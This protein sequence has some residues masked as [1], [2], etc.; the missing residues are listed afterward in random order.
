MSVYLIQ[1]LKM[2]TINLLKSIQ[3]LNTINE[4]SYTFDQSKL[5]YLDSNLN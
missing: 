3:N 5:Y 1:Q 2:T 4:T